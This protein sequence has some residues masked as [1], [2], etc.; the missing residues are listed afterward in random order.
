MDD[1]RMAKR[2][3]GTRGEPP[4][5][6]PGKRNQPEPWPW[7]SFSGDPEAEASVASAIAAADADEAAG[8]PS[9][10]PMTDADEA[11]LRDV[12]PLRI[13][14]RL[15]ALRASRSPAEWALVNEVSD[16]ITEY[17]V[18]HRLS[19]RA[20]AEQLGMPQ[21]NLAR[22]ELG[23]H[24]PSLETLSRLARGLGVRFAI[25]ISPEGMRLR[26]AA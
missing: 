8:R 9:Y 1:V 18:T 26:S 25:E 13:G 23:L 10:R 21:P 19:Q 22:L 3:K 16:R 15:Q 2:I 6:Q 11:R 12:P 20:L 17:R 14:P 24:T 4:V 7:L 5:E